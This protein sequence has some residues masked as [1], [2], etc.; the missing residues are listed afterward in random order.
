MAKRV[1]DLDWECTDVS[2]TTLWTCDDCGASIPDG[3]TY[4]HRVTGEIRHESGPLSVCPYC[5][6]ATGPMVGETAA[7][8]L[9]R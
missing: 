3:W 8:L 2:E 9:G 7:R 6:A 1:R 5:G 4:R